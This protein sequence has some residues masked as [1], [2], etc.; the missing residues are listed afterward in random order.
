[1]IEGKIEGKRSC[2]RIP[3]RWIVQIKA[4]TGY[5]LGEAIQLAENR[6]FWKETVANIN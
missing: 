5:L 4:I 1:M 2:G 3:M 6:E